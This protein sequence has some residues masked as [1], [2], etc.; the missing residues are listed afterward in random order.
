[1]ETLAK[2]VDREQTVNLSSIPVEAPTLGHASGTL[3]DRVTADPQLTSQMGAA[4]FS[5]E[6]KKEPGVP[7]SLSVFLKLHVTHQWV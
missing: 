3:A 1:M 5:T 4:I 7:C 6:H 2:T